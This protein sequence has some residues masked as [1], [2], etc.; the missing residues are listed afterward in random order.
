MENIN[1]IERKGQVPSKKSNTKDV[2]IAINKGKNNSEYTNFSF[3]N[4]CTEK[5]TTTKFIKLGISNNRIYFKES[6][7]DDNGYM[8]HKA[9]DTGKNLYL[10]TCDKDI[11]NI[12]RKYSGEYKLMFD[13]SVRL[14]FIQFNNCEENF[15]TIIK[16]RMNEIKNNTPTQNSLALVLDIKARIEAYE[17]CLQIY[18]DCKGL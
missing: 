7:I 17:D 8:L 4:N 9:T 12:A 15:E 3:R 6:A 13:T 18:E 14:P 2:R 5:I 10:K 1:W 16:N 11:L